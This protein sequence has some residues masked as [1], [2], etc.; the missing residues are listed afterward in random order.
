MPCRAD[1]EGSAQVHTLARTKAAGRKAAQRKIDRLSPSRERSPCS[2]YC[3][4]DC[5]T[6]VSLLST[7]ALYLLS[8][9]NK[10]FV[11]KTIQEILTR[12]CGPMARK[13]GIVA[14]AAVI[15]WLTL[16]GAKRGICV[17]QYLL[18]QS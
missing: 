4:T 18:P 9:R 12:E 7:H 10:S 14:T 6:D 3:I 16:P 11:Y 15:R 8:S 13:R 1:D 5:R 2:K 17:Q